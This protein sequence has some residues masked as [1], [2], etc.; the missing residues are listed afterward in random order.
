MMVSFCYIVGCSPQRIVDCLSDQL[1]QSVIHH[2]R[3]TACRDIASHV[4]PRCL[5]HTTTEIL[6]A[7]IAALCGNTWDLHRKRPHV[8]VGDRHARG[9]SARIIRQPINDRSDLCELLGIVHCG[10]L[11]WS[12]SAFFICASSSAGWTAG[13]ATLLSACASSD[14]TARPATLEPGSPNHCPRT[15]IRVRLPRRT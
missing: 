1:V 3:L 7:T 4:F 11:D 8:H 14:G 10:W 13:T 12:T 5:H 2:G 6:A 9:V 15:P